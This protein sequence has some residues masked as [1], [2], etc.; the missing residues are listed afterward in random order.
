MEAV[1]EFADLLGKAKIESSDPPA[2]LTMRHALGKTRIAV[3]QAELVG[4]ILVC[5]LI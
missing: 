2:P 4:T 3:G 1:R 5:R